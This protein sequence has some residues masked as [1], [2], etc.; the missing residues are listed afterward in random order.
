MQASK[1][2]GSWGHDSLQDAVVCGVVLRGGVGSDLPD[3]L[4]VCEV[5]VTVEATRYEVGPECM[6]QDSV[7]RQHFCLWVERKDVDLW[8]V[9][10]GS[11]CYRKDGHKSYERQPSSRTDRYKNAYRFPLEQA[12]EIAKKQVPKIRLGVGRNRAGM[13]AEEVWAWEQE[14]S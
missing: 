2:G 7:N 14:G 10:D 11:F 1:S 5:T 13:T 4:D 3:G 12:L 8:C 6:P 9:T